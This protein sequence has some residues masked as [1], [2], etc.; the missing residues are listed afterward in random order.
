MTLQKAIEEKKQEKYIHVD[1]FEK[2][3]ESMLADFK[4]KG[5]ISTKDLNKI[6][7]AKIYIEKFENMKHYFDDLVKV[8]SN[9]LGLEEKNETKLLND[10]INSL[11]IN[12]KDN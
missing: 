7:K 10:N 4:T 3:S 6:N 5:R 11:D 2:L 1:Y 9:G 8:E 12:K